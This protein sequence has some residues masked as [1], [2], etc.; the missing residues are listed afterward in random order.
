M[1]QHIVIAGSGF[2]GLWAALSAARA[3][4]LAGQ[5]DTVE[6]TVVSPEAK[7]PIRPRFYEASL[8]NMEP[9][10]GAVFDAVG[11]RHLAGWVSSVD[12][13]KREVVIQHRDGKKT[14]LSYDRFVL[15]T[16]S[17]VFRPQL[18]GLSDFSFDVDSIASAQALDAH[19][20][21]LASQPFSASRNTVVVIGGG[22][23]GLEAATEMPARL[24]QILGTEAVRVVMIERGALVGPDMTADSQAQVQEALDFCGVEAMTS[25]GVTAID[26]HGVSM[27][28]GSRIEAATVVWTAGV[29][30]N[31]LAA[32]LGAGSDNFGRVPVDAMMRP[33]GVP[34]VFIAG[35]VARAG[36]DDVG[37]VAAMSCQHAL[38]LGRVAGHNAAAELV[39]LP[40]HPY[41]QPKYVMC[42]DL[43]AWGAIYTEGWDRQLRLTRHEAKAVKQEINTKWIYP[44]A[45]DREAIFAIANPD[46]VIVP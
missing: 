29:R 46:H 2:A 37:N 44:P 21:S 27:S 39:G 40:L 45:P 33:V 42:L 7:L 25:V 43:G 5:S 34:G 30:A 18:P 14:W 16:G 15:A 11:V 32:Q 1:K 20:K 3:V 24:R 36:S 6:I 22:F 12:S 23:T 4:S 41:S 13:G 28:D 8:D 35:D 10:L 9:E 31:A 26:A 38:S 17:Q 19:L